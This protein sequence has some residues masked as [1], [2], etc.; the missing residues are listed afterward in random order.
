ME[1]ILTK[2]EK[3][4]WLYSLLL[5]FVAS[6]AAGGAWFSVFKGTP[7]RIAN[8]EMSF[9]DHDKRLE[10]IEKEFLTRIKFIE[11][12]K[13]LQIREKERAEETLKDI[14]YKLSKVCE[15]VGYILGRIEKLNLSNLP[16][17]DGE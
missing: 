9:T 6:I 16:G 7:E 13:E 14:N 8:L 15:K 4:L 3:R 10:M 1:R 2:I 5:G 12:E 17:G 11:K